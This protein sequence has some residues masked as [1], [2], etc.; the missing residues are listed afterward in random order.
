[1]KLCNRTS[2][3]TFKL[4]LLLEISCDSRPKIHNCPFPFPAAGGE[5]CET[6]RGENGAAA[7]WTES[8]GFAARSGAPSEVPL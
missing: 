3:A 7:P 6:L 1:M 5:R 4:L 8:Y 2:E